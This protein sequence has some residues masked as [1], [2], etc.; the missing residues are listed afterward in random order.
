VQLT[1]DTAQPQDSRR[2]PTDKR[3]S[4]SSRYIKT[5][6]EKDFMWE[7]I[8]QLLEQYGIWGLIFTAFAESS[9]LP[10]APDFFLVPLSLAMP[11]WA[12][13]LAVLTTAASICGAA[14]GYYLGACIGKPLLKKLVSRRSLARI[15]I[16]FNRYG[17]GAIFV[18]ALIPLPFKLFTISAGTFAMSFPKFIT[19]AL[20]GRGLRFLG[21][22][23][24]MIYWGPKALSLIESDLSTFS[25]ILV[26]I[27]LGLVILYSYWQRCWR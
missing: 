17:G 20:I 9:F 16:L 10:L 14:F 26:A 5:L 25:L 13:P 19:A 7:S 24:L 4:N 21:E 27:L 23:L 8:V 12:L 6:K 1:L 11:Y 22:A 18:A 15:K 2:S 3:L